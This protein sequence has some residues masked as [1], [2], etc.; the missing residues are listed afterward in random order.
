MSKTKYVGKLSLSTTVV[1]RFLSLCAVLLALP[2]IARAVPLQSRDTVLSGTTVA[3]RPELAGT[4]VEDK[5]VL[6][7]MKNTVKLEV[8]E[9][10]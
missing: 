5:S 3:Q 6:S 4:V 8:V 9:D 2:A 1:T 7:H 10:F